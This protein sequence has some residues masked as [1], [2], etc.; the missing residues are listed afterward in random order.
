M[1]TTL[2][3]E[4]LGESESARLTLWS[5]IMD[6][7]LGPGT[8]DEVIGS[9]SGR[10]P[11]VAEITGLD[12][13]YGFARKFVRGRIQYKRS[14]NSGSRGVEL[15]FI[16]ESGKIYEVKEHTSWKSSYRYFCTVNYS[17][18]IVRVVD[19]ESWLKEH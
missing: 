18:D 6:H 17:G 11:W 16:L 12:Q 19:V 15:W 10:K 13:K 2:A 7:T 1:K 3:L 14:N 8:S 5:K 4:Y 9:T